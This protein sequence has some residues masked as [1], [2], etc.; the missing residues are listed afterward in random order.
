MHLVRYTYILCFCV[1]SI[2]V[3]SCEIFTIGGNYPKPEKQ[4]ELK[5]EIPDGTS[6][7]YLAELNRKNYRAAS[8]FH[9]IDKNSEILSGIKGAGI[10]RKRL[11][12]LSRLQI[13]SESMRHSNYRKIEMLE[14]SKNKATSQIITEQNDTLVLSLI[15][16]SDWW[17]I[18]NVDYKPYKI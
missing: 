14:S 6:L 17:Y 9:Y 13:L 8:R 15:K 16:E 5:R 4:I 1:L 11:A 18:D 10:A 3:S 7:L 2:I 12:L